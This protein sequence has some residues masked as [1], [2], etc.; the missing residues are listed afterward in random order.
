MLTRVRT[1]DKNGKKGGPTG[2]KM[3][4]GILIEGYRFTLGLNFLL[5]TTLVQHFSSYLQEAW[6][7]WVTCLAIISTLDTNRYSLE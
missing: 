3:G 2:L 1:N 5:L 6:Y 7:Q 4:K